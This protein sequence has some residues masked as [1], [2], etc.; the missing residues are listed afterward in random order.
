M[1]QPSETQAIVRRMLADARELMADD[2]AL[3][4]VSG[5]R[6]VAIVVDLLMEID[7]SGTPDPWDLLTPTEV[8]R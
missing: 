2:N 3:V 7:P 1:D 5:E 8:D 4:S 6:V